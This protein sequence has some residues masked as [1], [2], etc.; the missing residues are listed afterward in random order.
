MCGV[1]GISF[2]GDNINFGF[3]GIGC[4]F[5][6]VVILVF[7]LGEKFVWFGVILRKLLKCVVSKIIVG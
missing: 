2:S 6:G 1:V 7:R 3:V 5:V 4:C